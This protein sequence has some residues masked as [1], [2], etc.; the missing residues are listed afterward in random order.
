MLKWIKIEEVG[1]SKFFYGQIVSK[2]DFN[3]ENRRIA[4]TMEDG[5]QATGSPC[6]LGISKAALNT[7]S[8]ISAAAFQQTTRVLT[9]AAFYGK[10]DYLKG[11]KE[12]V[13]MGRLIPAGTGFKAYKPYEVMEKHP[14][15]ESTKE[16]A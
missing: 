9:D 14:H 1:D 10:T 16:G 11:I 4:E 3:K 13:T 15:E 7:D 2:F 5:H 8:F 12:N 6:L